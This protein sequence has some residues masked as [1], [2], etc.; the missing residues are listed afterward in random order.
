MLCLSP[1]RYSEIVAN[2]SI[3]FVSPP[4]GPLWIWQQELK[5]ARAEAKKI[6]AQEPEIGHERRSTPRLMKAWCCYCYSLVIA[7]IS[8]F[9]GG[10]WWGGHFGSFMTLL[11][12]I[13]TAGCIG[14]WKAQR[15]RKPWA[16][17]VS[18]VCTKLLQSK[19]CLSPGR[20]R[21]E[22]HD[23]PEECRSQPS[24]LPSL[25][26][27]G[28]KIGTSWEK[29]SVRWAQIWEPT[30]AVQANFSSLYGWCDDLSAYGK[31]QWSPPC[32]WHVVW[33]KATVTWSQHV[34]A[35]VW[36]EWCHF[37]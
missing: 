18:S 31:W 6:K 19:L 1:I 28:R 9:F 10:G 11:I 17:L 15:T 37:F 22:H 35:L 3:P 36:G 30:P 27:I 4:F 2:Y 14:K 21:W 25:R 34:M 5:A 16:A 13:A 20:S 24:C 32:S 7:G 8:L 26:D 33:L 29:V 12:F 23:E